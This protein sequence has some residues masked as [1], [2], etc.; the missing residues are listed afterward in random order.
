MNLNL[1]HIA[2]SYYTTKRD[3]ETRFSTEIFFITKTNWKE[4]LKIYKQIPDIRVKSYHFKYMSK[5]I[6]KT[7]LMQGLNE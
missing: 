6:N 4:C 1:L 5:V 7:R 3:T 2:I